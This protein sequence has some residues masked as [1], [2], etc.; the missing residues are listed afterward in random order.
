MCATRHFLNVFLCAEHKY[1]VKN[2]LSRQVIEKIKSCNLQ[3]RR[4]GHLN[5]FLTQQNKFPEEAHVNV[6]FWTWIRF[7][8]TKVHKKAQCHRKT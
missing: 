6:L 2:D 5:I 3:K 7:K 4:F 1:V 8:S